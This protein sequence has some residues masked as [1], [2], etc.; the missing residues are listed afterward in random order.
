MTNLKKAAAI[1]TVC[2]FACHFLA[3][4]PPVADVNR[5]GAVDLGDAI[6]AVQ[7]LYGLSQTTP[8]EETRPSGD[9]GVYLLNAVEAFKVLAGVKSLSPENPAKTISSAGSLVALLPTL[10]VD[11]VLPVTL[12]PKTP[13][14]I[15]YSITLEPSSPPPE[16]C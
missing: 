13:N 1:L 8:A 5:S 6:L 14:S 4:R 15:Y 2:F 10:S 11:N 16:N 12:V 9:L 7:A 3:I